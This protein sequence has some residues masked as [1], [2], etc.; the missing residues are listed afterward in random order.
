MRFIRD[1]VSRVRRIVHSWLLREDRPA[2][3][4]AREERTVGSG[5]KD[6]TGRTVRRS[7]EYVIPLR[8][9]VGVHVLYTQWFPQVV[10]DDTVRR[11]SRWN[12]FDDE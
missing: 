7:T 8:R 4:P 10:G 9:N 3:V 2:L 11:C 5:N 6:G 1:E 12:V